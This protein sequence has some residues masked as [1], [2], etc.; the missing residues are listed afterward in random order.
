MYGSVDE[1]VCGCECL[2][3]CAHCPNCIVAFLRAVSILLLKLKLN[4]R[5]KSK[6]RRPVLSRHLTPANSCILCYTTQSFMYHCYSF[7]L[8]IV[9]NL[10]NVRSLTVR[11]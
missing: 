1:C 11:C 2:S 10:A 5:L 3:V 6:C 4:F 9:L 8:L 7:V